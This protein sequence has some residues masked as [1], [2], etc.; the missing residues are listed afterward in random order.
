MHLPGTFG[1]LHLRH[2][3]VFDWKITWGKGGCGDWRQLVGDDD[4]DDEVVSVARQVAYFANLE[5]ELSWFNIIPMRI[6]Y[7]I[8]ILFVIS[9][10]HNLLT[11]NTISICTVVNH[12]CFSQLLN[13]DIQTLRRYL[14]P[15]KFAEKT[16][17]L[18]SVWMPQI[19]TNGSHGGPYK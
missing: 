8:Y 6:Y 9:N 18:R 11:C 12:P 19:V 17:H 13:L 7:S 1:T 14:E 16:H 10:L 4:D 2:L 15:Q 5:T 3:G